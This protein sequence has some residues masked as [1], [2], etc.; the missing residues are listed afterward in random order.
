MSKLLKLAEKMIEYGV[1]KGATQ[2]QAS[3]NEGTEFN[4]EIR[5]QNI[6]KLTEAGSIGASFKI[7]VDQKVA[8]ASSSDLKEDTL[9]SLI[10]NAITRAKLTSADEF[11]A[12]PDKEDV[13]FDIS[14]LKLYD[15]NINKMTPEKKIAYAKKIEEIG[16][17][18]S[19]INLSAGAFFGTGN[20]SYNLANSNGFSGSYKNTI[21]STG[22]FLQSGSGDNLFEDGWY[23]YGRN[24]STL[25]SEEVLA[26]KAIE[27]TTLLMGAKKI[28][29]QVVPVIFDPQMTGSLLGFLSSCV[30]GSSIYMKRSFLVDKLNTKIAS[31]IV[32]IY[33][34]GLLPGAPGTRPFDGEGVPSRKTSVIENGEL[35]SYLL[36]TYSGRKL[37]M[38]STGNSSG[39]TNFYMAN[40]TSTPE[41]IIKS[42]KNG[43]YLVK[44]M[45]QGTDPTT[46][47]LSKGAFG[48]WIENGKLTYPVAEITIS[49][50][51]GEM[52]AGIEMVGNDLTH[53][54]STCGP[55]IK[56]AEMTISGK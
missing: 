12:L 18:D 39:S 26:K 34:D 9:K 13:D 28:D 38:K 51:L 43:L 50:Q 42:V 36:G 20:G 2:M 32:N 31:D 27:R 15:E 21:F 44:T 10:D 53:N 56:V 4:V 1:K 24:L 52:L 35:K 8:T 23:E 17:S 16:K 33:D 45:G 7:I 55:T 48:L 49:G 5:N 41:D 37:K 11:S 46:G 47:A 22:V 54:R 14:K 6:E 25:P 3:I 19:R 30:N 29:T 40:G